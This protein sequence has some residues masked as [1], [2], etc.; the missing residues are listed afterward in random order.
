M[1]WVIVEWLR[2]WAWMVVSFITIVFLM[3]GVVSTVREDKA[4]N[5]AEIDALKARI[6]ELESRDGGCDARD[7]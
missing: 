2:E 3:C 7:D 4:K 5:I 1:K 6:V